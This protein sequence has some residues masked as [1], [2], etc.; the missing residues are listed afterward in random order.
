VSESAS[1]TGRADVPARQGS[2]STTFPLVTARNPAPSNGRGVC[3]YA[4]VTSSPSVAS[5]TGSSI[6][7]TAITVTAAPR[8]STRSLS[9]PGVRA[10]VRPRGQ[11]HVHRIVVGGGGA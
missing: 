8:V 7:P 3:V 2:T 4:T 6:G 5:S 11:P 1:A 10:A 9:A